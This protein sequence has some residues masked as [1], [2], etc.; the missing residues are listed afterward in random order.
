MTA[1][2]VHWRDVVGEKNIDDFIKIEK[3]VIFASRTGISDPVA[4]VR[5]KLNSDEIFEMWQAKRYLMRKC[6]YEVNNKIVKWHG[7]YDSY[8]DRDELKFKTT[9]PPGR[10]Y[11]SLNSFLEFK[12]E[13][14]QE[15]L[16][17]S[18]YAN[19]HAADEYIRSVTE[20]EHKRKDIY[21]NDD[22]FIPEDLLDEGVKDD[23]RV[24]TAW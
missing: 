14:E 13:Y 15:V 21:G 4:Y 18:Y 16:E 5:K 22:V 8:L 19:K 1:H 2:I 24:S 17:D 20:K 6:G 11:I 9:A 7:W 23:T 10:E 12:R 3:A